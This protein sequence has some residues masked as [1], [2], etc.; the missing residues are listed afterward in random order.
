MQKEEH[1][2]PR[3]HRL[4]LYK[5]IFG[6]GVDSERHMFEAFNV[7]SLA[8]VW[9]FKVYNTNCLKTNSTHMCNSVCV[10][11]Q[12]YTHKHMHAEF[13]MVSQ[14]KGWEHCLWLPWQ[15]CGRWGCHP[16]SSVE[17]RKGYGRFSCNIMPSTAEPLSG[18]TDSST[19]SQVEPPPCLHIQYLLL[20][21]YQTAGFHTHNLFV[22]TLQFPT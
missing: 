16:I 8:C 9:I 15:H 7:I 19:E 5:N 12:A 18:G 20:P 21:P 11:A 14:S 17:G 3:T 6:L 10:C 1:Q 13:L 2:S 4:K 22:S